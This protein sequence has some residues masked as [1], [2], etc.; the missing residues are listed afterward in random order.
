MHPNEQLVRRSYEAFAAGDLD[1]VRGLFAED[2][3]WHVPGRSSLAG[4]HEGRDAVL[5]LFGRLFEL[6]G[7][8][9]SV[10]VHD[11]VANDEHGAAIFTCSA[12]REGRS[13]RDRQVS[14]YRISD[15][16]F[17]EAWSHPGDLYAFDTFFAWTRGK[18]SRA[19]QQQAWSRT[20]R[21]P[22]SRGPARRPG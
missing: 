16:T 8:T 5:G 6:S 1:T 19:A 14:V 15:G 18:V 7:G 12:E 3:V 9:F 20:A 4:D 10:E 11:A 21:R 13:L 17:T 2:I 22:R